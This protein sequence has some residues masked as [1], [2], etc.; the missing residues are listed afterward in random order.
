MEDIQEEV[1]LVIMVEDL[2]IQVVF[3]IVVELQMMKSIQIMELNVIV[4]AAIYF[5]DILI[6][7]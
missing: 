3:Q 5:N 7:F 6:I 1:D 4:I 2:K